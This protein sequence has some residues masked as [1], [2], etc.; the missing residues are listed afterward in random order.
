MLKY[1]VVSKK[2]PID[3]TVKY[4]ARLIP[5]TPIKLADLAEAISEECTVTVHDI[6]AVI[7]SLEAHIARNIRNGNSIRLGDIGSFW[8]TVQSTGADAAEEFSSANIK[9]VMVRFRSSPNMKFQLSKV[10]PSVVF[11]SEGIIEAAE[12]V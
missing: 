1:N 4:Y 10:N 9:Q 11:K 12:E 3:K 2:S 5:V 6:K 8:P 7:S